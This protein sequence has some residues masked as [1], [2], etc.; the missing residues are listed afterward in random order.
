MTQ[1]LAASALASLPP[2]ALIDR[3]AFAD[4]LTRVSKVVERRNTIPILSNVRLAGA[5]ESLIVEGCDLD[6]WSRVTVPA[7][8]DSRFAATVPA[9]MLRDVVKK[10]SSEYV[11]ASAADSFFGLDF[12][13]AKTSLQ[14][15]PVADWPTV[16]NYAA[17]AWRP[18]VA[19]FTMPTATLRRMFQACEMAIST[20][21][22]RYYLNGIFVHATKDEFGA[23]IIRAV[24]TDG[25]RLMRA[26]IPVPAGAEGLAGI[27]IPRKT[28]ALL[29]AEMKRKGAPQSVEIQAGETWISFK[30]GNAELRSKLVDGTFPDYMRVIPQ[31][32]QRVACVESD[33]LSA[34]VTAVS[35]ISSERGRA[36]KLHFEPVD[37]CA[38]LLEASVNNPDSGSASQC[39][40]CEM[41]G[42]GIEIGFHAGYLL[43]IVES[44]GADR[45]AVKMGDAGSPTRFEP[46]PAVGDGVDLLAV[47][48]PMRV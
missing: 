21:E 33:K 13:G 32:F 22:T 26:S 6:I 16:E 15:L 23:P 41:T 14:T 7:A 18:A 31:E 11:E 17:S 1:T 30:I 46:A 35:T 37:D 29:L 34:M 38:A 45:L 8:A 43:D 28:V 2:V 44:I 20:E 9:H 47:L 40:D 39:I 27:I 42:A 12:E 10:A 19:T 24:A 4:A 48:M 3:K 5:G 36:V 25:H